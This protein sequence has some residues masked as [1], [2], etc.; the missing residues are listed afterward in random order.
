M[1]KNHVINLKVVER[2]A[3]TLGEINND[4]IF[5][6]GAVV[7]LYVT[8]TGADL[9]R[10]T[11]DIDISVQV[12]TYTEMDQLREKLATKGIYPAPTEK[13]LYRYKLNDILIDFIPYE[14]TSLG[15]TNSWLKPGFDKAISVQIGDQQISILPLSL[16]IA[17]K[18]EAYKNRGGND[19]RTSHDFE[20][21]IYLFDNNSEIVLEI[22]QA[23]K[24]VQ[25]YLKEMTKEI[26][27]DPYTEENI[28]CH[29]YHYF[30]DE[31]IP[32]VIEKLNK[33]KNS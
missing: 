10:P 15:P 5:V 33:I 3:Q 18:W 21:I 12:S 29:I 13:I 19:P 4:V 31:R 22:N 2:V 25:Q 26:L 14:Q 8:E 6:G 30:Q 27:D 20:D 32:V 7:G 24:E 17:S 28:G 9:P 16:Y 11:K 23:D 1:L